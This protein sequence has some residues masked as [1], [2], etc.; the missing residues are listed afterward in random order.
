[1]FLTRM[2]V[3]PHRRQM[4]R[5]ARDPQVMHAAV[6]SA[7][8]P[9]SDPG[10][11]LWRLDEASTRTSLLILSPEIPSLEHLQEQIG[12]E[13]QRTWDSREYAPLLTRLKTGQQ[14]AFRLTANPTHIVTGPDGIGRRRAHVSVRYQTEWLVKR[15][16][17]I[18]VKF[19]ER[20]GGVP[21]SALPEV[22]NRQ[23]LR[24]RRGSNQVTLARA[25][26]QGVLEV[27][28]AAA[29]RE[30]MVNGI[31]RGKAYGCG[32]MTLAPAVLGS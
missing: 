14:Y 9:D 3:N 17:S 5:M 6:Q 19:I 24:F 29:L 20:T 25:T 15:S 21:E 26:Y 1:M 31:G 8:P 4:V 16:E 18:G 11:T 22:T 10:R 2:Y 27:C 30:A 23:T 13:T 28:D 32:L 12:W 7:F